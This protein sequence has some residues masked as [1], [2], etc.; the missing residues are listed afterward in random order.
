MRIH[1]APVVAPAR[2]EENIPGELKRNPNL[3]FLVRVFS[4]GVGV[5]HVRGGG[6]QQVRYV[7]RNQENQTFWAGYAGILRGYPGGARKV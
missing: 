5:F 1:V 4:G 7:P 3:N 2:I 6:G